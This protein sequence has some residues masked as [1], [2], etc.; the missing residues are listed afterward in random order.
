PRHRR[1]DCAAMDGHIQREKEFHD[2]IHAD[3]SRLSLHRFYAITGASTKAYSD[4]VLDGCS[5]K[6][7]LEMGCGRNAFAGELARRG[8][9]V[10]A[11]DISDVAVRRSR[12]DASDVAF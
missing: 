12:E 4:A 2:K 3:E 7:V 5:G 9:R 8:A 10:T 11:F 6:R 1:Y